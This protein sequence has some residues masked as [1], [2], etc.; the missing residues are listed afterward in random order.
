VNKFWLIP[1]IRQRIQSACHS[2]LRPE[3]SSLPT[4]P[5]EHRLNW[6][7]GGGQVPTRQTHPVSTGDN[8]GLGITN[9]TVMAEYAMSLGVPARTLSR[10][11]RS[12]NTFENLSYSMDIIKEQHL[13]QPT[14]GD[15]DLYTRRAVAT[16]R[17]L[18][19]QEFYWSRCFQKG[20]ASLRLQMATDT[21]SPHHLF[22]TRRQRWRTAR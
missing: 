7:T 16:A 4:K 5:T 3:G 11:T 10:K 2:V 1:I 21:F 13:A 6:P 9:S 12:L 20:P 8:Q 22:A 18:G 17:K 19:W 14:F 15:L